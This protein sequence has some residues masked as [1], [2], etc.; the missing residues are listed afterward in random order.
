MGTVFGVMA[1]S[2]HDEALSYCN[3]SLACSGEG[4]R[5]GDKAD[6][7]ALAATVSF[8]GGAIAAIAGLFVYFT[9]PSR[10]TPSR[11]SFWLAPSRGE[12][13]GAAMGMGGRF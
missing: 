2:T 4:L 9:A 11:T 7:Q 12:R 5:L 1:K 13:G 6:S 8:A 10:S 3:D